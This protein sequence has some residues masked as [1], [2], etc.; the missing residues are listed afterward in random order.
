M[1]DSDK[2]LLYNSWDDK[3][4]LVT[5]EEF[6]SDIRQNYAKME[7]FGITKTQAPYF[8]PPYEQN[9]KIITQWADLEQLTLINY[10]PGTLSHTDYTTPNDKNYR[11]SEE[12]YRS[13]LNHEKEHGLNGFM[14]LTHIG[15]APERKDKF[16]ER[17]NELIPELKS[18]GYTFVPLATLL[19]R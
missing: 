19:D 2:H 10:T 6:R 9:D 12:I 13:I 8:L 14:L 4:L 1:V 16:Y 15:T 7:K 11:N 18:R 17:L 3:K 5:K